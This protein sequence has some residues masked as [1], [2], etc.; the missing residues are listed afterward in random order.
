[1]DDPA[2]D[3]ALI[4][5]AFA[6]AAANGW[7]AVSAAA[8]ARAANLPLE[9]ARARFPC[10]EAILLRFGSLADQSALTAAL[11]DGTPR[12]KLFDV[13]MR[14]FDALQLHRDGIRALLRALPADPATALLLA[15]ATNGSMAWM[16]EGAGLSSTGLHGLLRTKGLVAVWLYALRAWDRDDSADLARTMSALDRALARAE[17]IGQWLDRATPSPAAPAPKPFPEDFAAPPTPDV[18]A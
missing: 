9:Q 17:E 13:L 18:S 6:L 16:L 14:R 4:T 7:A 12:D 8:A 5:A 2:F 10:R 15:A 3:Q 1:M 11:A